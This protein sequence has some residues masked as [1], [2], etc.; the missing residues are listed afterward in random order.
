MQGMRFKQKG[1]TALENSFYSDTKF[2]TLV[3]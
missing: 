2:K 3:R 1:K